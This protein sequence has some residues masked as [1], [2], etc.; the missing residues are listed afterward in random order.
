MVKL[1]QV[2]LFLLFLIKNFEKV[3]KEDS[4][5]KIC[6]YALRSRG[7]QETS[8]DVVTGMLKVFSIDVYTLFDP[9]AT[10][11]FVTLLVAK[12]FD[13]LPY[14]LHEPFIVS[15]PMGESVVSK[16]VYKNCLLKLPNRVSYVDLVE[17]DMFDFDILFGMDWCMHVFPLLMS[18][19]TIR[20]PISVYPKGVE[21]LTRKVVR[22]VERL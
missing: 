8:L 11:F 5:K 20:S 19:P 22:I 2:V 21:S 17:L 18:L 3:F 14:I 12:K 7:E 16:R 1:K 15:T 10:L 13:I 6:F 4:L 9:G